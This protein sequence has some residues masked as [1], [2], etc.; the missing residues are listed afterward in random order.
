[1]KI[2]DRKKWVNILTMAMFGIGFSLLTMAGLLFYND[3]PNI[4]R[5]GIVVTFFLGVLILIL[6][7]WL[8]H[9]SFRQIEQDERLD[10]QREKLYKALDI[11]SEEKNN[12]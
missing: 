5:L 4:S 2:K 11:E 8:R 1:M 7:V 3:P 10:K 9:I 6:T 12:S